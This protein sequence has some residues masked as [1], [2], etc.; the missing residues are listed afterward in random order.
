MSDV[1][2]MPVQQS[3]NL[4]DH[5]GFRFTISSEILIWPIPREIGMQPD[6]DPALMVD[7]HH[8]LIDGKVTHL[9]I[10]LPEACYDVAVQVQNLRV[11]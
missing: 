8:G 2:G 5:I 11:W 4:H 7:A 9:P 10:Y 3:D 1:V 6:L